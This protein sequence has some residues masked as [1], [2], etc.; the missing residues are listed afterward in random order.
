MEIVTLQ[1]AIHN[2]M[3]NDLAFQY[4]WNLLSIVEHQSTWSE[5]M[6]L[7][8]LLYLGRLYEKILDNQSM[9]RNG[10]NR[11]PEPRFHVLYNGSQDKPLGKIGRSSY[12]HFAY[13][14][15]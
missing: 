5:N 8:E 15:S 2:R 1:D 12:F 9:Y 11:V 3:L 14:S 13:F 7:R 4:Q 6:P 10:I